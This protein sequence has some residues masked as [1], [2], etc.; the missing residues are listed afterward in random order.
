MIGKLLMKSTPKSLSRLYRRLYSIVTSSGVHHPTIFNVDSPLLVSGVPTNSLESA[1]VVS[2][3]LGIPHVLCVGCWSKIAPSIV[4]VISVYMIYVGGGPLPDHVKI[5]HSVFS[6]LNS[7]NIY[8]G[9]VPGHRASQLVGGSYSAG[10]HPS[11]RTVDYKFFENRLSKITV[12]ISAR[13]E[14]APYDW[15]AHYTTRGGA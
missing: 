13:H 5:S 2:R 11:L 4:L 14:S 8:S 7:E 15:I 9:A 3:E 10:K 12:V 6:V 1:G